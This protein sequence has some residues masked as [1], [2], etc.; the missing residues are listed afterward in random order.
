M[1]TR[2]DRFNIVGHLSPMAFFTLALTLIKAFLLGNTCQLVCGQRVTR[3]VATR[4]QLA[5]QL[6]QLRQQPKM[7]TCED[8]AYQGLIAHN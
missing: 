5:L 4:G 7:V 3:G 2:F 8:A 6:R 1:P